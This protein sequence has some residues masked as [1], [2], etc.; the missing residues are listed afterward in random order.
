MF[1]LWFRGAPILRA[2]HLGPACQVSWLDKPKLCAPKPETEA[3]R[4]EMLD[5]G[6]R[7]LW[8]LGICFGSCTNAGWQWPEGQL[9]YKGQGFPYALTSFTIWCIPKSTWHQEN[10]GL[11]SSRVLRTWHFTWFVLH[12]SY[13]YTPMA[14][15]QYNGVLIFR[16]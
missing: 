14:H 4:P 9:Q 5:L 6:P 15:Q 7:R 12:Q 1:F 3:D 8:I 13:S 2:T 11:K 10:L 16:L